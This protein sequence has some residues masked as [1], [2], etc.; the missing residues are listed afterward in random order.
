MGPDPLNEALDN[1]FKVVYGETDIILPE[2][3]I[4]SLTVIL[5]PQLAE[6]LGMEEVTLKVKADS[7]IALSTGYLTSLKLKPYPLPEVVKPEDR[8]EVKK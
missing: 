3:H 2:G 5:P 8:P 7:Y 6:V 4:Q 1:V